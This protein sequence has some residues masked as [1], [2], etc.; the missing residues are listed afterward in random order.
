MAFPSNE[1]FT[2][3]IG[4]PSSSRYGVSLRAAKEGASATQ[5]LRFPSCLNVQAT[6]LPVLAAV[7]FSGNGAL[8]SSSS[9]TL[10]SA[11]APG[12]NHTT[13]S[14]SKTHFFIFISECLLS[15]TKPKTF[16]RAPNLPGDAQR[17]A[18]SKSSVHPADQKS[19]AHN[20][21]LANWNRFDRQSEFA[22]S[23]RNLAQS[24]ACL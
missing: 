11:Q 15:R 20:L 6:R 2:S 9:V 14:R 10:F 23:N 18:L 4:W 13:G 21:V 7:R 1:K 5:M 3:E 22:R 8:I 17:D 24:S 12:T 19:S 16:P